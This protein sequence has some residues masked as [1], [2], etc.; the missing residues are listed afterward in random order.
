MMGGKE[1]RE[2]ALFSGRVVGLSLT[3]LIKWQDAL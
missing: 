1:R 2:A 3:G